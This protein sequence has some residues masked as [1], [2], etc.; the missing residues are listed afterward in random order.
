MGQ[1]IHVE[2]EHHVDRRQALTAQ[3]V[4][5]QLPPR[6]VRFLQRLDIGEAL[7]QVI[8]QL[9]YDLGR[10]EIRLPHLLPDAPVDAFGLG[11]IFVIGAEEIE[12][13]LESFRRRSVIVFDEI[14]AEVVV[15]QRCIVHQ[16]RLHIDLHCLKARDAGRTVRLV[17]DI[18]HAAVLVELIVC[19]IS[20]EIV[21]RNEVIIYG[22]AVTPHDDIVRQ[23]LCRVQIA[24]ALELSVLRRIVRF[25]KIP[26]EVRIDRAVHDH[27]V[28]AYS[29][30]GIVRN[31]LA[32][33]VLDPFFLTVNR[34]TLDRRLLRGLVGKK[35][36]EDL[37]IRVVIGKPCVNRL[38]HQI[39]K[40]Q[41][42]PAVPA[43]QVALCFA[44][45]AQAHIEIVFVPDHEI[46][47]VGVLR[48]TE[49][50]LLDEFGAHLGVAV[51]E[52]C[53]RII[54]PVLMCLAVHTVR[55]E[56][57]QVGAVVF[58]FAGACRRMGKGD[59]MPV[60]RPGV[61]AHPLAV[62]GIE[63]AHHDVTHINT[64]DKFQVEIEQIQRGGMLQHI[65]VVTVKLQTEAVTEHI[66]HR[67]DYAVI[68]LG[69]DEERIAAALHEIARLAE[70]LGQFDPT[71]LK[72]GR[73]AERDHL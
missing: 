34:C 22:E 7:I 13:L 50:D 18:M 40:V 44:M 27:N 49:F 25:G 47:A 19:F 9:L 68:I 8:R 55:Q 20:A 26:A 67:A 17:V 4:I 15:V 33:F 57:V 71:A 65:L 58:G 41:L 1:L 51:T 35:H 3:A 43:V 31:V 37:P 53:M 46:L 48:D 11:K 45:I 32:V 59:P 30:V 42:L 6:T 64:R 23:P 72:H 62:T 70:F 61:K 38:C 73:L 66:V 63:R 69:I 60:P 2:H 39:G 56:T 14:V 16:L 29:E 12:I 24:P 36:V 54:V 52:L 28:F 21:K 5:Q 10:P